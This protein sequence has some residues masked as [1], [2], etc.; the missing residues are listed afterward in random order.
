MTARE[1]GFLL[2][3]ACMGDPE[4]KCLTVPQLR[5][6]AA[7]ASA[8]E[9][10][11]QQRELTVEDLIKI[12]CEPAFARRVV[13]LLCQE[14][15][16][17]WYLQAA[18]QKSCIPITRISEGYPARLRK[19]LQLDAPGSL[20]VKGDCALLK[21]PTVS[22]VGSRELREENRLFAEEVGKQ[23]ALQGY[24]L[25]SGNARG[26]DRVAQE[27]CL[28]HGGS[29]ISVVADALD[30]QPAK[31]NVLYIS[32][33]GFDLPFSATRALQRNRIIH[34]LS[35]KTFVV[36]CALGKGG[37]W[38]GTCNNLR[39]NLSQVICFNDGSEVCRKLECRGAVLTDFSQ[40]GDFSSIQP[41]IMNFIDQ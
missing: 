31:K 34:S 35:E 14:E 20:W 26:A 10:P 36:Q 2:L 30:R 39:H 28:A 5:K 37:T 15:Q 38:S 25:V 19:V 13:Q 32:E 11:L 40:L 8:M 12:G 21:Q 6:L 18:K 9:K 41:N 3:T 17:Q 27:S 29:V 33:E 23:A 4:R 22:V 7:L 16:L 24:T 1:Q